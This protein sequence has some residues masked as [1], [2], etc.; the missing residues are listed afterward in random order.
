MA[1]PYEDIEFLNYLLRSSGLTKKE[2]EAIN[3]VDLE[4]EQLLDVAIDGGVSTSAV[5]SRRIIA[6]QKMRKT[7]CV[8]IKAP[9]DKELPTEDVRRVTCNECRAVAEV[10][11]ASPWRFFDCPSGRKRCAL[12]MPGR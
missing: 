3:R 8:A 6:L 2:A 12:A 1:T 11:V 5:R 9:S 7:A 4:G 10:N